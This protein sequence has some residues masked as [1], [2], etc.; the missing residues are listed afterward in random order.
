MRYAAIGERALPRLGLVEFLLA[1]VLWVIF[2]A[3][4]AVVTVRAATE[5]AT[6]GVVPTYYEPLAQWGFVL[7]YVYA[8][9]GFLALLLRPLELRRAA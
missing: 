6:T 9:V 8:V 1:A 4:R 2:S 7:F 3:F 5:M